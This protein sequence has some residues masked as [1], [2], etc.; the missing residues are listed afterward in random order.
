[1]KKVLSIALLSATALTA[2]GATAKTAEAAITVDSTRVTVEAGDTY[3]SIAANKG[4]TIAE[5]EQANGRE[6]G[7]F[8]LIFPGETVYLPSATTN[9]AAQAQTSTLDTT[10]TQTAPAATTEPRPIVTPLRMVTLQPIQTSLSIITSWSS[11]ER[12]A[13]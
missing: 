1:M 7:G 4:I 11:S 12:L 3:K 8:D 5:L 13:C 10:A 2:M 6:V 9:A